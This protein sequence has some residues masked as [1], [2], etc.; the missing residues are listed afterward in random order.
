MLM[1]IKSKLEKN[2]IWNYNKDVIIAVC[3]E[4]N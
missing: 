4:V 3:K 2:N 1:K